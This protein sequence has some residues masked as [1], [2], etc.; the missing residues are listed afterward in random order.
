M[1]AFNGMDAVIIVVNVDVK[2]PVKFKAN[3]LEAESVDGLI[4]EVVVLSVCLSKE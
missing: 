1:L 4:D 2:L 3:V